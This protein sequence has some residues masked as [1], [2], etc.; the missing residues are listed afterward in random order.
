MPNK[1]ELRV[2]VGEA[3]KVTLLSDKP[4]TGTN[5]NGEWN[6]YEVKSDDVEYVHFASKVAH[7][8]LKEYK[9]GDIVEIKHTRK[10]DGKGT[11]YVVT[12]IGVSKVESSNDTSLSIKWGMAFNNATKIVIAKHS[13]SD[14]IKDNDHL[15][16]EVSEFTQELF[17]VACSMPSP[18]SQNKAAVDID[19]TD[20]PF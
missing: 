9:K 20:V 3:F 18:G 1:P 16:K 6:M 8:S 7:E 17:K 5:A 4:L 2:A 11:V 19:D 14:T 15:I 12:A 13:K 10:A